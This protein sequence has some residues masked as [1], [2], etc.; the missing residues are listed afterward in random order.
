MTSLQFKCSAEVGN[1]FSLESQGKSGKDYSNYI[2]IICQGSEY[3]GQLQYFRN[4]LG[5]G[6]LQMTES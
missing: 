3:S 1:P 6:V 2:L 4:S 5:T